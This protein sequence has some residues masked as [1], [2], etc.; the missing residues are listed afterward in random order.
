M[1][2]VSNGQPRAPVKRLA[3]MGGTYGNLSALSACLEDAARAGAEA[4]AFLGDS[5][6]CCGH[7]EEIVALIRERFD[8]LVAGCI[9]SYSSACRDSGISPE[10]MAEAVDVAA[11][12]R[13]G[14][15]IAHWPQAMNT[16]ARK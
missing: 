16:L 2:S 1:A 12:I 10:E 8:I 3:A 6:G 11:V 7:S 5:I 4:R 13:G 15:T 9:D 14:G